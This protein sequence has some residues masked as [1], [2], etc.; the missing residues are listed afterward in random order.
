VVVLDEVRHPAPNP[1]EL[2]A[3][4]VVQDPEPE[5][6][7]ATGLGDAGV[8][9][10]VLTKAVDLP[11]AG[12]L[13]HTLGLPMPKQPFPGQRKPPCEPHEQRELHGACWAVLEMKPPCGKSSFD[14]EERCYMPVIDLP[15]QPASGQQ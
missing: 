10:S 3:R 6:T 5:G 4:E 9:D 12:A 15:R 14:Y 2:P 13:I 11:R 7:T 1:Q 8:D